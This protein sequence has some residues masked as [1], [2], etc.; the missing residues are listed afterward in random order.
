M[1]K[2]IV[3]LFFVWCALSGIALWLIHLR[4][5]KVSVKENLTETIKNN[6]LSVLFVFIFLPISILFSL[7][8]LIKTKR[9]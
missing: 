5:D 1:I 7:F 4:K 6:K 2:V 3:I 9:K 8:H